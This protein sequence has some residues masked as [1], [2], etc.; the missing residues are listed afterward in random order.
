MRF[1]VLAA[2]S[3][4]LVPQTAAGSQVPYRGV[5]EG[6]YGPPWGHADRLSIIEFMGRHGMNLYV[7]APK[8]DPYHRAQWRE[9]YPPQEYERLG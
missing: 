6:F 5:V 1:C 2:L 4:L 7:Y 8:D 3:V 9:P